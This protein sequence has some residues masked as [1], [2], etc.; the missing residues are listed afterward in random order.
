MADETSTSESASADSQRSPVRATW[1]PMLLMIVAQCCFAFESAL[2]FATTHHYLD[3]LKVPNAVAG[4]LFLAP[5]IVGVA[6][7]IVLKRLSLH[8]RP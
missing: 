5:L 2:V 7:L 4:F 3:D 1:L 6:A 8:L